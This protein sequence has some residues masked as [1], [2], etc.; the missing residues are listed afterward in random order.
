MPTVAADGDAVA[1]QQE[2][3]INIPYIDAPRIATALSFTGLIDHLRKEHQRPQ[4]EMGRVVLE[5]A[6]AAGASNALLVLPAWQFNK[7]LG[8]KIG[9]YFPANTRHPPM[10]AHYFLIDGQEGSPLALLDGNELTCWKTAA[11]SALG[12]TMLAREDASTLLVVGAGVIVPHLIR[13]YH[14][15]R[16]GM[17]RVVVWNRTAHKAQALLQNMAGH[18]PGIA[19]EVSADLEASARQADMI[20][21]ATASSSPLIQGR[22]LKPGTHLDLIGGFTP[23][24][25]EADDDAIVRAKLYVDSRLTTLNQVGDLT[26]PIA[27]GLIAESHV[28]GDLF[29]LCTGAVP[30]RTGADELTVFKSGGGAHL[31]LMTA[32]YIFQLLEQA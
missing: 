15:V 11:D 30:G 24:M 16:P 22:W 20:V 26:Q 13:A 5:Q 14:A 29:E 25:R 1:E 18:L 23:Q 6:I 28:L 4:P 31:D 19:L 10:Q 8:V 32:Q 3:C 21:C 17:Q 9:T 2:T 7:S 12:A 27:M